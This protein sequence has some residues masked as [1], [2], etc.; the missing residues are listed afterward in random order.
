MKSIYLDHAA[1]TPVH[2]E[3]AKVIYHI[4]TE[5]YGN[6]SSV[7][8]SGRSAKRIVN[9]ARDTIAGFLGCAPDEWVFTSGGTESDNLALLGAAAATVQKGKHIITTAIEHHAVL[10][11]CEELE[12]QGY[13]ITYLPA[14]STGRVS[15]SDVEAALR[16]DTV[17]ISVMFANNEVGTVQPVEE[18]GRLAAER[19][20]LFHVDAVQALGIVPITLRE[21]PVDYMSFSAH[22]INGPQ[23]IGGLYVRRGAPL[24]P[25]QHGGLQERGRRAGTES[26]AGSAGFAKAVELAAEGLEQRRDHA[27]E[28]RGTLLAEL[29]KRVGQG[30]YAV[31]GNPQHFLPGILNVSFPGADTDVMLM[32]LDMERIAAASGSACT[33]GSLEISHVLQA[34]KLPP[35]LLRSAIRFSTGLGNTKEEMEHVAQKVETILKRLRK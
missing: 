34:M 30:G 26:L 21:L 31:N 24:H 5:E 6:A 32:N 14:D 23:G 4:L 22:K 27:L 12:R 35:E 20:V 15:A 11:T 3:V 19:G 2:P 17:L 33:S 7:H 10:H 29:E 16:E 18:I 25:R 1:S 8:H 28:L 9:G 13:S